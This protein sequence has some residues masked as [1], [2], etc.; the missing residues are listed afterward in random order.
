M[1]YSH[2]IRVRVLS[3]I[4]SGGKRRDAARLFRV[5]RQTVQGWLRIEKTTGQRQA[6]KPGPKTGRKV[7]EG[8]LK[9][10]LSR[11]PDAKLTE[12]GRTFGVHPSTICY[13]CKRWKITRKKNVGLRRAGRYEK[14]GVSPPA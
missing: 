5:H 8:A 3:Y 14:K 7:T 6:G 13:A 2:D 11:R 12:L 1:S 10:V 9:E 4:R